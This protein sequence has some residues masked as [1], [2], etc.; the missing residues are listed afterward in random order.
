MDICIPTILAIGFSVPVII[1]IYRGVLLSDLTANYQHL[2]DT[3]QIFRGHTKFHR[4]YQAHH[5]AQL[6]ECVL[7]HV[8]VH[9][10]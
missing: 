2:M 8:S 10:L 4:V 9:G 6:K 3:G 7:R 1:M 5:K